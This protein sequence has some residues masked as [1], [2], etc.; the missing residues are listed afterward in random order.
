M[1]RPEELTTPLYSLAAKLF[2]S[3]CRSRWSSNLGATVHFTTFLY[4]SESYGRQTLVSL[5]KENL[6]LL[7]YI[8][9]C[10]WG[11]Q[12]GLEE[13]NTLLPSAIFLAPLSGTP[14][15]KIGELHTIFYL[16]FLVLLVYLSVFIFVSFIKNHKKIIYLA[17]SGLSC[18]FKHVRTSC[19]EGIVSSRFPSTGWREYEEG[20][21]Q[22]FRST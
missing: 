14:T 20:M 6:S 1:A 9:P 4:P 21:G 8:Q 3:V 5:P 18:L 11:N 13:Y 22:N 16:C 10:T 19:F 12:R 2:V 7:Y 15:Y 17:F